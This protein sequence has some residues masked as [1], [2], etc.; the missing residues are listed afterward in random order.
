MPRSH[1][2]DPHHANRRL[3]SSR[4]TLLL[5]QH[6]TQIDQVE[7]RQYL[8]RY[9][10][11]STYVPLQRVAVNLELTRRGFQTRQTPLFEPAKQGSCDVSS[12]QYPFGY[13]RRPIRHHTYGD[14]RVE[15][16]LSFHGSV[17]WRARYP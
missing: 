1:V 3:D 4:R 11:L 7:F 5:L 16:E 15:S 13:G 17:S 10:T 6:T 9:R 2:L 12:K 14:D 8:P